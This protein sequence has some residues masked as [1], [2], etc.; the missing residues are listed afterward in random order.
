MAASWIP[1]QHSK[2]RRS[3]RLPRHLICAWQPADRMQRVRR[4]VLFIFLTSRVILHATILSCLA[5][6][7]PASLHPPIITSHGLGSE[8]TTSCTIMSPHVSPYNHSLHEHHTF[9]LTTLSN[10]Q[11]N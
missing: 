2:G 10:T 7:S 11:D 5:T 9:K 8:P 4:H 1:T 6:R 3:R